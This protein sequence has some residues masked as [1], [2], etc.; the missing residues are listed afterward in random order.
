[1]FYGTD[2]R[3]GSIKHRLRLQVTFEQF[4][5]YLNKDYYQNNEV[6]CEIS[7][8]FFIIRPYMVN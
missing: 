2:E 7:D 8:S 6:A 1:M 4:E 3:K 5:N